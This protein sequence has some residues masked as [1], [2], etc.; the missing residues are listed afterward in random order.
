MSSG[1]T[2]RSVDGIRVVDVAGNIVMGNTSKALR[3]AVADLLKDDAR[4]IILNLGN[5]RYIDS[6]GIGELVRVSTLSRDQGISL[7][8]SA[9]PKRIKDLMRLSG[10][11]AM[12]ESFE[13]EAAAVASFL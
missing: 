9:V 1:I 12:F 4:K 6:S 2:I 7:K 8:L 13:D 11:A 3:D 5:V 10:I